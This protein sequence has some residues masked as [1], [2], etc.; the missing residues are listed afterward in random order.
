MSVS[1]PVQGPATHVL[2]EPCQRAKA[3]A[4]AQAEAITSEAAS[5][6]QYTLPGP[7]GEDL[8]IV[9][10]DADPVVLVEKSP[11]PRTIDSR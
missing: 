5:Q 4:T 6:L 9:L 1:V 11:Q 8:F 10:G 7:E 2:T 3:R